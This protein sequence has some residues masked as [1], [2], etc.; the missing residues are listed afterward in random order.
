L[1]SVGQPNEDLSYYSNKYKGQSVVNTLLKTTVDITY[2]KSGDLRITL[3]E[4]QRRIYLNDNATKLSGSSVSHSTQ[5]RLKSIEAYSLLP[6][7]KK[8]R[9]EKVTE[10]A[11]KKEFTPGIFHDGSVSVN[12]FFPSLSKGAISVETYVLES[13]IPELLTS[14]II[15]DY[16]PTEKREITIKLAKGIE[17]DYSVINADKS[18][19]VP[20]ISSSR[21]GKVLKWELKE[22]PS[23]DYENDG[24]AITYYSPHIVPRITTYLKNGKPTRLLQD[25]SDLY[26]WCSD[27]V[28]QTD[29]EPSAQIKNLTDSLIAG[30]NNDMEKIKRI[31]YWVQDNVKYVAFEE[32][33]QGFIPEDAAA[34][35]DKRFGDCKGMTSLLHSMLNY[36]GIEAYFTWIGSRDLPYTYD[37]APTPIADNHMI[38]TYKHNDQLYFLDG[39]SSTN[40]AG[41]PTS[42]IQG[43]EALIGLNKEAYKIMSVPVADPHYSKAADS[44]NLTL[45][46]D[47]TLKGEGHVQLTGYY[48]SRVIAILKQL[49]EKDTEDFLKA[50]LQLGSNKFV[51]DS[52]SFSSLAEREQPLQIYYQ[53]TLPDYAQVNDNQVYINLNLKKI[54]QNNSLKEKRKVPY[55]V[56][57]KALNKVIVQFE[58]PEGYSVEH[59]PPN[60]NFNHDLFGFEFISEQKPG[61]IKQTLS[62]Y[63]NFLLLDPPHF[64]QWNKMI[65][66]LNQVHRKSTILK[67][68]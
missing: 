19:Y 2:D 24:P 44:V 57:H 29:V 15:Q 67:K 17:L 49:N 45:L 13:T 7:E 23:F 60:T 51:L 3:T 46:A 48:K 36:A 9:K 18:D 32:G 50:T 42:F 58:Y 66:N 35:C 64:E 43:K 52:F 65:K 10:Y 47:G 63:D 8:F 39:T 26:R 20:E 28:A 55:E 34:V 33:L 68:P 62:Q 11:S 14:L 41:E 38:I 37:Q 56:E 22:V 30:A 6:E 31:Y 27:F 61:S 54:Y 1:L 5:Y 59:I 12:Y 16:Y 40:A 21:R 4:E 53:F 25:V